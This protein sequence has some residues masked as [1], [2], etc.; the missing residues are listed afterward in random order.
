MFQFSADRECLTCGTVW[1]P[2]CPIW[3]ALIAIVFGGPLAL[4]FFGGFVQ[5]LMEA[6]SRGVESTT[7]I[8][9]AFV[10]FLGLGIATASAFFYGIGVLIGVAGRLRILAKGVQPPESDS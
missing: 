3:G 7:Q 9:V 1:R 10:I 5:F 4:L 6:A 8:A 2:K